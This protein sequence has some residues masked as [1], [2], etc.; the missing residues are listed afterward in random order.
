MKCPEYF[1]LSWRRRGAKQPS[2]TTDPKP[3]L[4][5]SW[6]HHPSPP[7]SF[8]PGLKP[9]FSANS[10]HRS[11]FL[12]YFFTAD[13]TDFPDCLPILLSLSVLLFLFSTFQLLVTCGRFSC[14][15]HLASYRIAPYRRRCSLGPRRALECCTSCIRSSGAVVTVSEFGANHKCPDS[16]TEL[17]ISVKQ[18]V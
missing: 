12:A 17:R 3:R 5:L 11:L 7:H 4:P 1:S 13:S 8:I 6:S 18:V 16:S 15:M 10:S 9:P 14:L 2:Y